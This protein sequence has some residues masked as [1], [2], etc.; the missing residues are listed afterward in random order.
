MRVA[1]STVLL[2]ALVVPLSMRAQTWGDELEL[3]A[4]QLAEHPGSLRSRY[5][6]ANVNLRIAERSHD[7]DTTRA[8]VLVADYYYRQML[9]LDR[10]DLVALV[11]LLYIDGKYLGSSRQTPAYSEFLRALDKKVFSTTDYIA[12]R[13]FKDC[14]VQGNCVSDASQYWRVLDILRDRSEVPRATVSLM[15]ATYIAGSTDDLAEAA[16]LLRKS[17]AEDPGTLVGYPILA[18]WE[19]ALGDTP[20]AIDTLRRIYASDSQHHRLAT[21]RRLTDPAPQRGSR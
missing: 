3:A 21:L 4:R 20:A 2:I 7:P 15:Q 9:E 8:A 5:H 16:A 14:S 1:L 19:I 13:F 12:L 18:R 6:Y 10:E 11:T 17:L